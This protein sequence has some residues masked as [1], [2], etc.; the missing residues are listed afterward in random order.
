MTRIESTHPD[1]VTSSLLFLAVI[2]LQECERRHFGQEEGL[3][4]TSNASDKME[5]ERQIVP[6][7]GESIDRESILPFPSPNW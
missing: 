1:T 7:I 3:L 5:N 6:F 4:D 2:A